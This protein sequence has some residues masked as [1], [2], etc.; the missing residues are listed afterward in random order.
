MLFISISFP[1]RT[2]MEMCQGGTVAIAVKCLLHFYFSLRI[3]SCMLYV[4]RAVTCKY[5]LFQFRVRL[6]FWYLCS[7]LTAHSV[8]CTNHRKWWYLSNEYIQ[9]KGK[10]QIKIQ[11]F[12]FWTEGTT[13]CPSR[14]SSRLKSSIQ[15]NTPLSETKFLSNFQDDNNNKFK[16]KKCDVTSEICFS[17]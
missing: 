11:S 8:V 6:L 4:K 17:V 5:G 13:K 9:S 1:L 2:C 10:S 14:L 12:A 15:R 3:Y 16:V 7:M